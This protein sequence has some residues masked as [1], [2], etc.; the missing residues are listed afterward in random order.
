MVVTARRI[1]TLTVGLVTALVAT[2][3]GQQGAAVRV[4]VDTET[5]EVGVPFW[6]NIE[7]TGEMTGVPRLPAVDGIEFDRLNRSMTQMSSPSGKVSQY[8]FQTQATKP[9][10]VT[11]PGIRV[12]VDGIYQESAPLHLNVQPR[13]RGMR[14]GAQGGPPKAR[15][16]VDQ[17][18]VFVDQTFYIHIEGRGENVTI[19]AITNVDGLR[20]N[21]RDVRQ[22]TSFTLISGG[23]ME[24][25]EKRSYAAVALSPGE[26]TIPEID[27][28]VDG[29]VYSTPPFEITAV[30][31]SPAS[32][33]QR[34]SNELTVDDAV[35]LRMSTDKTEVYQ[36]EPVLLSMQLWRIDYPNVTAGSHRGANIQD[37][38]TEGFYSV[39]LEPVTYS[40][41]EG[42]W[43]Y[44]VTEQRHL[45]YPTGTGDLTIGSW[46][47]EGVVRYPSKRGISLLFREE[48]AI[49][50]DAEPIVVTV[51]PLPNRPPDFSGAVGQFD[52]RAS[53]SNNVVQQGVPTALVVSVTGSG[54]PD[55]IGDPRLPA[56]P[57][58]HV[59]DPERDTDSHISSA[60]AQ[61]VVTKSFKYPITPLEKGQFE[62]GPV[63]FT[64]FDPEREE[65][66]TQ[67]AGPFT[68]NV[69]ESD[70][71]EPNVVVSRDIERDDDEVDIITE[72]I[73]PIEADP[74]DLRSESPAP[75]LVGALLL[76][77]VLL[78]LAALFY[79]LQRRR[80]QSDSAGIR[81]RR[82]IDRAMKRL[83]SVETATD[84]L[85][86]LYRA[87]TAFVAD[88]FDIPEAGLT[89]GDVEVQLAGRGF[90]QDARERLVNILR[91]CERVRYASHTLT[92]E[93]L[94]ALIKGGEAAV[95]RVDEV[96]KGMT[97]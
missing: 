9:G 61:L 54:N 18:T 89:S 21:P 39:E 83:A 26:Y 64:Y 19:P 91:R 23:A 52:V 84:P 76:A 71:T 15:A 62:V 10:T 17:K 37:P 48:A 88:R 79:A 29:Q 44:I 67:E 33:P 87:M 82:A 2:G 70:E 72:D 97:P 94:R 68:L 78:Y 63:T 96:A 69:M 65:Y 53:I 75:A 4:F 86:E 13:Q 74:G 85:D 12:L 46:H 40:A 92:P 42:P 14:T 47:W 81:S 80:A 16:W 56:M 25:T 36:G 41:T 22:S 1:A 7:V 58:A 77:P 66:V 30:R 28:I 27:V 31:P 50:R 60:D 6:L 32:Q 38:S 55:A 51:K 59:G 11:I 43:N 73:Q 90:E 24:R 57:W 49:S 93:E 3:Y 20:I 35:L 8:R 34:N 5:I 45:L 95:T